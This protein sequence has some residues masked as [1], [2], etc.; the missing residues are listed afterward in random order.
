MM[1]KRFAASVRKLIEEKK[2]RFRKA[3]DDRTRVE[4]M[5]KAACF[6]ESR[7]FE[8]GLLYYCARL[9][10]S[11]SKPCKCCGERIEGI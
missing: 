4:S 11:K 3:L 5:Y 9:K 8:R 6:K 1:T 2:R 7:D 10:M